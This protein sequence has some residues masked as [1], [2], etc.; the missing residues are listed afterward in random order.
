QVDGTA[1]MAAG[2]EA[3]EGVDVGDGAVH[4]VD[5]GP[6]PRGAPVAAV[7]EDVGGEAGRGQPPGDMAVA[8]GVLADAVR[9]DHHS[10]GGA[11][12]QPRLPV[13]LGPRGPLQ[14]AL[15][16]LPVRLEGADEGPTRRRGR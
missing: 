9:D 11:R 14:E 5:E 13:D 2:D 1:P 16:V 7:V 10:P 3:H 15:D 4:A 8:P 6:R 12:W